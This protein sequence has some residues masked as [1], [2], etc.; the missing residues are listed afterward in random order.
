MKMKRL[1]LA[2][3]LLAATIPS[4]L[5]PGGARAQTG[6]SAVDAAKPPGYPVLP[7]IRKLHG[8]QPGLPTDAF[9]TPWAGAVTT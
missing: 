9:E 3:A 6:E 1:A 4:L 5:S 7:G 2:A 8:Q